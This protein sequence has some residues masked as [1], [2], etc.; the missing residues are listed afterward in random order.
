MTCTSRKNSGRPQIKLLLVLIMVWGRGELITAGFH[1]LVELLQ[2]ILNNED[3][4]I[5]EKRWKKD[6]TRGCKGW[7]SALSLWGIICGVSPVPCSRTDFYKLSI[8][9]WPSKSSFLSHVT[10]REVNYDQD[11]PTSLARGWVKPAHVTRLWSMRGEE[12]SAE[13]FF[14]FQR[15]TGTEGLPF[16]QILDAMRS[17]DMEASRPVIM[18]GTKPT[19]EG[20]QS[21]NAR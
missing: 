21:E 13:C 5:K 2:W 11:T 18:V 15:G 19:H 6:K 12:V 3:R 1:I 20:W 17:L 14:T 8:Y 7:N 4:S 10:R 9:H 16:P